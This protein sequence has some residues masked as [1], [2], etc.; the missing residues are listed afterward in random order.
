[1]THEHFMRRALELAYSQLGNV[2]PNPSVGAVVVRGGKIIAEGVTQPPGGDHAEINA[3]HK[4]RDARGSTLYVTLEPCCHTAK[5]TP[6][7]VDVIIKAG[8]TTVVIETRAK[9][10]AVNGKGIEK[11]RKAGIKVVEDVLHEE[12]EKAHEFFFHWITTKRPFVT[13][14]AAMT[15]NGAMTWGDGIK[16]QISGKEALRFGHLLRKR[17]DAILVG[18]ETILKDNP[19]LT[20][21]LVKGRDPLRVVLDSD[22]RTPP[23]AAVLGNTLIFCTKKA[24]HLPGCEIIQVK[25][26][27]GHVD[28]KAVLEELGKRGVTSLLVEGGQKIIASF[29]NER[30]ANKALFFIAP[31]EQKGQFF[32]ELLNEKALSL[33]NIS[34]WRVGED[35]LIEGYL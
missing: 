32:F 26:K 23:D 5:R 9:N 22:L 12:A 3:L 11:L 30:H 17:Y 8:I 2:S 15:Q 1:M 19:K 10:P 21:R 4:I 13:I 18:V 29:L 20:V 7:C 6:P 16:K 31:F 24:K 14:K 34:A 33:K 25:E 28:I 35:T 27:N